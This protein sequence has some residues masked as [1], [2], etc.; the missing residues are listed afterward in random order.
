M[1][2]NNNN[3]EF[4]EFI[5]NRKDLPTLKLNIYPLDKDYTKKF[6]ISNY[7]LN[8]INEIV[9][10]KKNNEE[11]KDLN[12]SYYTFEKYSKYEITI[13]FHK[14][15]TDNYILEKFNILDYSN[16]NIEDIFS[17]TKKYN[18]INDKFYIINWKKIETVAITIKNKNPVFL[19]AHISESQST[20]LLKNIQNYQFD[21]IDNLTISKPEE[22]Y[23]SI[24]MIEL[25]EYNT[26][27][28]IELKMINND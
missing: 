28:N 6:V 11:Y 2:S 22:Y 26:E 4:N 12:F 13:K 25:S 21:E 15:D 24:L 20:N 16:M 19:L 3:I 5:I 1:N 18:D 23:Y 27:V 10:I 17:N 9:S 7:N 8:T 14:K